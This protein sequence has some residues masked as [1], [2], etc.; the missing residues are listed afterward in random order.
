MKRRHFLS[1]AAG[2][3][4]SSLLLT[5]C[6]KTAPAP[7]AAPQGPADVTLR[8]GPVL[9][10]IAKDHTIS[11]IG[12]NGSVPGPL[13]RLK[14]GVPVTVDLFNDTD[15]PELVHWH[16]MVVPADVDGAEEEKSLVVAPHGHLRYSFTPRPSGARFVHSHVMSMRISTA[17]PIAG[18]SASFTSSPRTIPAP[19]IRKSFSR[20]RNGSHSSPPKK[21]KKTIPAWASLPPICPRTKA[22]RLGDRLPAVHHQRE[23]ARLRRARARKTRSA[24]FVS[25][26]Q[27]QRDREHQARACPAIVF[28]WSGW[29]AIPCR[30]PRW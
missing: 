10:D 6:Q 13:I 14:E 15:T 20:P 18:S 5:G 22:Q 8:I 24:R 7:D 11:T 1:S 2:A 26:P 23:G 27:R 21:R 12:Y 4:G 30:N 29:T 9:A 19:T 17:A 3:F 25:H 28:R 16:G